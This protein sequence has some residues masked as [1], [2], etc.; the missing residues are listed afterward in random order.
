MAFSELELEAN[1]VDVA[2]NKSATR[3][4]VLHNSGVMLLELNF[5]V[6]PVQQPKSVRRIAFA[7]PIPRQIAFSGE[8]EIIIVSSQENTHVDSI[9]RLSDRK[10]VV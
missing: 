6:K 1:A 9:F 8:D 10:S 5:G 2:I 3:L 7:E 4:A